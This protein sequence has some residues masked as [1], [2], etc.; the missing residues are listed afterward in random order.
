MWLK[1]WNS[2]KKNGILKK[3]RDFRYQQLVI[4]KTSLSGGKPLSWTYI[5]L[6]T[7]YRG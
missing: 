3:N 7:E 2:K 6:F 5:D 4:L 1:I